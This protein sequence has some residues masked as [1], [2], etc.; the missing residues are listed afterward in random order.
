MILKRGICSNDIS[1]VSMLIHFLE[2]FS[3]AYDIDFNI[4]SFTDGIEFLQCY[5]NALGSFHILF[6]DI[7]MPDINGIE[8]A[9]AIRNTPDRDVRIIFISAH[10]KYIKES[11]QVQASQY[12]TK[13][14]LQQDFNIEMRRIVD[15]MISQS[16][17]KL[18]L[19]TEENVE[20]VFLNNIIYIQSIDS[21]KRKLN[22]V[23]QDRILCSQGT[24][25]EFEK[26]LSGCGFIVPSQGYLIN[27]RHLDFIKDKELILCNGESI[28]L[29]RRKEKDIRNYYDDQIL[30]LSKKR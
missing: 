22:F 1:T 18:I 24:I 17:P 23:L 25:Q 26:K 8:L 15:D 5:N 27:L 21:K 2:R 12:F 14:I 9:N 30:A 7:S 19:P 6:L 28:P 4:S 13:P 20:L 29:S 3:F 11:F 16:M 10:N